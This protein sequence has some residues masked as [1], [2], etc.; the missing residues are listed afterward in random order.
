MIEAIHPERVASVWG[1]AEPRL[2]R[3]CVVMGERTTHDVLCQLVTGNAQLW[4]VYDGW[5]VT[6]IIPYP[7]K[8]VA[9]LSLFGGK[10]NRHAVREMRAV[11]Y[12]WAKHY[13]A[14]EIRVIGRRGWLKFLPE[15]HEH[16]V[17][18]LCLSPPTP[19][20]HHPPS[21]IQ[22]SKSDPEA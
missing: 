5:A 4:R 11:L 18:T 15:A 19:Q 22:P 10:F 7:R 16:T 21:S 9:C 13:R 14:D 2:A 3:A 12:A 6:E 17:L 1:D 20:R 8:R